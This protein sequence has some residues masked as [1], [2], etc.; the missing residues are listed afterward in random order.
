M[1]SIS[2]R[3]RIPPI[4][5]TFKFPFSDESIEII[6]YLESDGRTR[7]AEAIF[8]SLSLFNDVINDM[9]LTNKNSESIKT[10]RVLSPV[11]SVIIERHSDSNE[12]SGP[13]RRSNMHDDNVSTTIV[14]SDVTAQLRSSV[15]TIVSN[16]LSIFDH[17]FN[18]TASNESGGIESGATSDLFNFCR[19]RGCLGE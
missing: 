9:N 16:F 19:E 1:A 17:Y 4:R 8:S 6:S 2:N 18:E 10:V 13:S 14:P 11:K 5:K 12:G 7:F 15:V 3:D